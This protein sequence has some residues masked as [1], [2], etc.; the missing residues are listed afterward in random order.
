[1]SA[2]LSRSRDDHL[3]P[4]NVSKE[5]WLYADDKR[6]LSVVRHKHQSGEPDL[7]YVPWRFIERAMALRPM[8][9]RK[10]AKMK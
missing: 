9:R 5:V 4:I 8:K 10:K 3:K 6:G 7:F 2:A 1:M